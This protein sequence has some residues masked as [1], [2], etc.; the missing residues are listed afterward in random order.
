[1][2]ALV[3]GMSGTGKSTAVRS[4]QARGLRAVDLDSPQW[5]EWVDLH[6]PDSL[7]PRT[8]QDWRW[9]E[10]R[11]AELLATDGDLFVSGCAANMARFYPLLDN[12]M[13]LSAPVAL[14][15]ARLARRPSGEYGHAAEDRAKV[16]ALV[17]RVEPLLRR[18][19][20]LVIDAQLPP[21]QVADAIVRGALG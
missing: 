10:D 16:A 4:L 5:S 3:T 21:E 20:D 8:A 1:M 12:I 9:R 2:K 11:V 7:M 13:L 18:R 6:D 14:L 15:S 19:A 17:E